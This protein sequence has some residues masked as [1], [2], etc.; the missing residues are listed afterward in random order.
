MTDEELNK[1]MRETF[2]RQELLEGI[3]QSVMMEIKSTARRERIRKWLR[4]L[5][6]CFGLPLFV[7]LMLYCAHQS[8]AQS[9]FS[10]PVAFAMSVFGISM[11]GAGYQMIE[12]FSVRTM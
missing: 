12:N 1:L 3:N 5:A 11:I 10:L 9:G 7:M 4:L 8:V 2:E 6:V